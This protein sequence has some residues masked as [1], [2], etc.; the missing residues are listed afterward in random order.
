MISVSK[1]DTW[2]FAEED[3]AGDDVEEDT[4]A[5][6]GSVERLEVP[7]SVGGRVDGTELAKETRSSSSSKQLGLDSVVSLAATASLVMN[8]SSESGQNDGSGRGAGI[9]IRGGGEK[10]SDG[11]ETADGI[12][13]GVGESETDCGSDVSLECW[14]S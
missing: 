3:G 8:Q 1:L 4:E 13:V 9:A 7:D 14:R 12:T 2:S 10:T 11:V 6:V 5:R